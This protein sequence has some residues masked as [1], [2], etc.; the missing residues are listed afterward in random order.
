MILLKNSNDLY[1]LIDSQRK[2]GKRN[3]FVP[4]MGALHQ[5]HISLINFSKKENDLT[6]CSIFV[7]PAQFNDPEDFEKYPKTVE[8]D[9]HLLEAAGCDILFLPSLTEVYPDQE[10]TV[11]NYDLGFLETALEGKFRPGHF[12]GVCKV[13]HRL[14][15]LVKPDTLYLGQKD[16]QQCMVITRLVELMKKEKEIKIVICPT[17]REK[18]GLAMSSRNT[19][20][21]DE[22][23]KKASA[24]YL[25]MNFI[26]ENYKNDIILAVKERALKMLTETG[27][28]VDYFEIVDAKNLTPINSWNSNKQFV[29]LVAAF[30]NKIR[31]IDNMMLD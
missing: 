11:R 30:L 25:A 18:D 17:L 3:G 4:T 21:N 13:V 26:K 19:R 31:L 2:K 9:I 15:D 10:E 28:R 27:F 8:K 24:I 20:L 12:Q 1:K 22:E 5:G 7:N 29:I 14:L 16:Y 23:R 6:I